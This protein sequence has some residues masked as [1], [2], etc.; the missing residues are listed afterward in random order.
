MD[1]LLR[2]EDTFQVTGRGLVVAPEL[3]LPERF[4]N[5]TG[6]VRIVPP[7]AEPYETQADFFLS[8]FSPGGFKLLVTF[9]GLSK[10]LLPIGSDILAPESTRRQL[11]GADA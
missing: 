2:V 3:P 4:R 7:G 11:R 9:P 6:L 10:D 8:H 1:H 5:F